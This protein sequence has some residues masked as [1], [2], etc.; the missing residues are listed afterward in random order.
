MP[1]QLTR[2]QRV[3]DASPRRSGDGG[4]GGT[5]SAAANDS[6]GRA[7][8]ADGRL[9]ALSP[10]PVDV[11]PSPQNWTFRKDPAKL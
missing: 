7:R 5:I 11:V 10:M 2:T 9:R 8:S 6:L 3:E 1:P 4:R